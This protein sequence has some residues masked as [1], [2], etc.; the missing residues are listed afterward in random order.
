MPDGGL[1]LEIGEALAERL[2][3]AA[4]ASGESLEDF[5]RHAL[6]AAADED[7]AEDYARVAEFEASGRFVPADRAMADLRAAVEARFAKK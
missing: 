2:R 6:E 3:L 1:K 5:A 4:Q 7:W